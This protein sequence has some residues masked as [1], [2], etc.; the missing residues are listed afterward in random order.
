MFSTHA[1]FSRRSLL[2]LAAG[3]ALVPTLGAAGPAIAADSPN[4]NFNIRF[5]TLWPV[6]RW[7]HTVMEHFAA[8]A[9]ELTGGHVEI[10]I[11]P[12]S[13]LGDERSMTESVKIG[14]LQMTSGG[15]AI[16]GSV[17]EVGLFYLGYFYHSY[18]HFTRVWTLGKSVVADTIAAAVE[19]KTGIKV[20]GYICGGARDTVLRNRAI[21]TVQDFKGLKIRADQAPTSTGVLKAL[22]ASPTP[23]PY[24]GVYQ[25]LQTGVVDAAE[26][27]PSG[28]L[29]QK[30]YEVSKYLSLTDHQFVLHLLQVN[31]AFWK[32]LPTDYQDTL[33]KAAA[34][35]VVEY[36]HNARMNRNAEIA[37]LKAKGLE[38]N[39]IDDKTPFIQAA[40]P[41]NRE[42]I[43]RLHLEPL[44]K[45][46][47]AMAA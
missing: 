7:D 24:S 47:E 46:I 32:G 29:G 13:Q 37:E 28:L 39:K 34:E 11:F 21:E 2:A 22:G 14:A 31:G 12:S 19:R 16:Q 40:A 3:A 27:P 41:Y 30:W 44:A 9:K 23:V 10:Q 38:V 35:A 18:D 4:R 26:N 45:A 20:L 42:F 6:N 36:N 15:G 8:R 43:A 17:P 33:Q 1:N 25:A 5:G